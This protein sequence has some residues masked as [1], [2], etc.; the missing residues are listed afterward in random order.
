MVFEAVMVAGRAAR[1]EVHAVGR[2]S[3]Y[4]AVVDGVPQHPPQY[5]PHVFDGAGGERLFV[6]LA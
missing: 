4:C 1:R 5:V 2:V 6:A 3:R